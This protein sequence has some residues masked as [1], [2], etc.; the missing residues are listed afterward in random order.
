MPLLDEIP[1]QSLAHVSSPLGLSHIRA[2]DAHLF[3][4]ARSPSPQ[5]PFNRG[6]VIEIQGASASGKTHLLYYLLIVCV[7]PSG[8]AGGWAKAGIVFDMDHSFDIIRF[9][10][11]LTRRLTCLLG[12][13]PS[14]IESIAQRS[15][16]RLRIFRPTSSSQ[17]AISLSRLA[18]YHSSHLANEEIG[19]VA[20]DSMS[21]HYW[22][23]RFV[24][25]QM[26]TATP[27]HR[28]DANNYVSP[29]QHVLLQI[30]SFR[31]THGPLTVMT[32]W[33]LHPVNN[34]TPVVY[35][36]HLHPFPAPFSDS[37][38][39]ASRQGP[40]VVPSIPG[41][42]LLCLTC[43]VTLHQ[44]TAEGDDGLETKDGIIMGLIRSPGLSTVSKFSLRITD[45]D[46]VVD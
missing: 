8:A 40:N 12:H 27:Q 11:L 19:M 20:I 33:G 9:K 7:T 45:D 21:A 24:A 31:H 16:H 32:N 23:D 1:V 46:I 13:S 41:G 2:L 36:Q 14:L 6:D 44:D 4:T 29:L 17:L 28:K 22:P 5:S 42:N 39:P 25:E 43:H 30:E 15:L 10:H 18:S 35:R 26:R 34:S 38:A 3:S 37:H